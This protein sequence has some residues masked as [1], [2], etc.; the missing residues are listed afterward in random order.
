[1]VLFALGGFF[2]ALH[3][4]EVQPIKLIQLGIAAPALIASYVNAQPARTA[5][6]DA[7]RATHSALAMPHFISTA[8]AMDAGERAPQ[9]VVLAGDFFSDAFRAV[10]N[11]LP[12]ARMENQNAKDV[13]KV[14]RAI[15]EARRSAAQATT[16]A[17][18]AAADIAVVAEQPTPDAIAAA[19]QSA[20]ASSAAAQKAATAVDRASSAAAFIK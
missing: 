3:Y 16:A 11:P 13:I 9:P 4:D 14:E 2:A 7:P 1:M 5:A 12:A 15:D 20:S 10:V 19:R 18:K 8:Q 6:L 17:D